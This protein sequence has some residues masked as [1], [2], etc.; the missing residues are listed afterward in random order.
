AAILGWVAA[1][2]LL[3]DVWHPPIALTLAVVVGALT[4]TALTSVIAE[5]RERRAG[6]PGGPGASGHRPATTATAT[7]DA[8]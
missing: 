4:V 5:R 6:G 2:L 8:D 1:K 3:V 7:A